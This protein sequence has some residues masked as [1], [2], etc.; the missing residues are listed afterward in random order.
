VTGA[1]FSRNIQ[2]AEGERRFISQ[3]NASSRPEIAA[4]KRSR[5]RESASAPCWMRANEVFSRRA[6]AR[7][8]TAATIGSSTLPFMPPSL[9][10]RT[11]PSA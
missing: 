9:R 6:S 7:L 10:A 5:R 3:M 11:R 2:P 1:S 4:T 8:R